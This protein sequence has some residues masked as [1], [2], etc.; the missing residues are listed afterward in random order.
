MEIAAEK[1]E[2]G[3]HAPPSFPRTIALRAPH[4]S[5]PHYAGAIVPSMQIGLPG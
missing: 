3:E 5:S 2:H 4:P 1:R